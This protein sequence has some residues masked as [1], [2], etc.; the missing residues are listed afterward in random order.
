M[1]E[2]DKEKDDE[3]TSNESE[4]ETDKKSESLEGVKKMIE[5][6]Q[7]ID[8]LIKPSSL[9]LEQYRSALN[10]VNFAK[11]TLEWTNALK[12]LTEFVNKQ[13][14]VTS[15][16]KN[17]SQTLGLAA[18]KLSSYHIDVSAFNAAS[19]ISLAKSRAMS[20]AMK[21][22][23]TNLSSALTSVVSSP[24][25]NWMKDFD[26]TPMAHILENLNFDKLYEGKADKLKEIYLRAMYDAK[27]FPYAGWIADIE[28]FAEINDILDSS[29]GMSKRCEKRIDKVILSYYT[30]EEVKRIKKEWRESDLE[31]HMK[32]A[33]GQTL[34]AYLRKEYA[35]VIPFLATMWEGLIKEKAPVKILEGEKL[36]NRDKKEKQKE[37]F[38]KLVD[39]NGF[40]EVFSD[41]YNNF[42]VSNCRS[43]NDVLDGV[44][45]RHGVAHSWYLRYPN[46]KAAL[47]AILLTDFIIKLKPNK[48]EISCEENE[49]NT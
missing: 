27:W 30:K 1:E 6:Q 9:A 13:S 35:L 37:E 23:Y 33:L 36:S 42:I 46:Q 31:P 40:G 16:L 43:L 29:R 25:M 24:F 44:P 26:F 10:A 8:S 22:I 14:A 34:E 20:V 18:I 7:K 21:N 28:V 49:K 17:Y 5:Q 39:E 47:N 32:K 2:N 12:P 19:S 45:N 4:G 15:V 38:E 41:F 3:N 48:D 11:P